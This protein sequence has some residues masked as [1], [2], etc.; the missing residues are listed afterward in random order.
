MAC[1]ASTA[2]RNCAG[3]KASRRAFII[4]GRRSF[5]KPASG[6]SC[7][8]YGAGSDLGGGQG[9]APGSPGAEGSRRR[10]G[11]G[12]AASQKKFDRGWG[13]RGMRYAASE[14]LEIIR[15]V[16]QSHLPGRETLEKLGVSRAT[17]YR[18]CDLYR[19]SYIGSLLVQLR[20][21]SQTSGLP[22]CR[23]R[24]SGSRGLAI[25]DLETAHILRAIFDG[26]RG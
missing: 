16:E 1:A 23:F 7:W 2:S 17:F 14:K 5:W 18:W 13:R 4:L 3:A 10:T 25:K 22:A 8:R 26:R 24:Q 19:F 21:H 20:Y 12:V 15:L 9:S 6:A 11:A